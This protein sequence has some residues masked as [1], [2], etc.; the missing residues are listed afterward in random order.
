MNESG[1]ALKMLQELMNYF[2]QRKLLQLTIE[3]E[4]KPELT[5]MKV[6]APCSQLPEDLERVRA[7]LAEPRKPEM[8]EYYWQL[9]GDNHN[10]SSI[11]LLGLLVD[12]VKVETPSKG[13]SV[14]LYR[15]HT[16]PRT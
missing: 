8:E 4:L 11:E 14:E 13:L 15:Y 9:L 6:S 12:E 10:K 5:R 16:Q 1:K 2:V 7:L 3:F